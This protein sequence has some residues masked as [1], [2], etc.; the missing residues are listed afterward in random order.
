[1]RDRISVVLA[2]DHTLFREGTRRILDEQP[3]IEVVG[4]ASNGEQAVAL[5]LQLQPDVAILDIAMPGTDGIEATHRIKE[6]LPGVAIII[7]TVHDEDEFVI[8]L[9]EAGAAGY[10]LKDVR[11]EQLVGA[12]RSVCAGE[13]VLHPVIARKLLGRLHDRGRVWQGTTP[14]ESLTDREIGVLRLAAKGLS[15]KDIG[16]ELDLSTRTV[17]VHLT[18]VF[19]KLNVASRTEAVIRGLRAGWFGLEDL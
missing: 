12:V 7:L 11:G 3:D 9:L 1:M 13:S 16:R 10:L 14:R 6:D 4:E 18:H 15:N 19:Q 2:D 17:Q 5:A 8:A